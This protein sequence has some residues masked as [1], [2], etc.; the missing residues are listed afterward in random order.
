MARDSVY[1]GDP[2]LRLK[3]VTDATGRMSGWWRLHRVREMK[4]QVVK[5]LRK[6]GMHNTSPSLCPQKMFPRNHLQFMFTAEAFVS[7]GISLLYGSLKSFN[8]HL[9]YTVLPSLW[10]GGREM[11]RDF[12]WLPISQMGTLDFLC[13]RK[14]EMSPL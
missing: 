2:P 11:C 14:K 10:G 13:C 5:V 12:R 4:S 8:F 3:L 1:T 9:Q 7:L 6:C